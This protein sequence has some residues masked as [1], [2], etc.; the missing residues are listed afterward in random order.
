MIACYEYDG[1]DSMKISLN[2]MSFSYTFEYDNDIVFFSYF[3]PY[4]LTD[5][6]DLLFILQAKHNEEHLNNILKINKLCDTV[7][8]NPCYILT[9]TND[10]K[11]N[12]INLHKLNKGH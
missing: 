12:D 9:I 5:L 2:T 11:K 1:E 4:T 8:G 6:Q 10:V 7:G 3:Q